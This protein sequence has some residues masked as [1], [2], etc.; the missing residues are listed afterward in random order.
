MA[1]RFFWNIQSFAFWCLPVQHVLMISRKS[2]VA[3]VIRLAWGVY[4]TSS[5]VFK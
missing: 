3:D 4:E 1:G 5:R 2:I